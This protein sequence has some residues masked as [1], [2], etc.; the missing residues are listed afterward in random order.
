MGYKNSYFSLVT[1]ANGISMKYYP[2]MS[3]GERLKIEDITNYLHK[4]RI[5]KY[6]L[7][8]INDTIYSDKEEE[9]FISSESTYPINEYMEVTVSPDKIYAIARFYPPSDNGKRL[10][11]EEIHSDLK[12]LKI[13]SGITDEYINKHLSTP[14]YMTQMVVAKGKKPVQGQDAWIE[15]MFNTDRHAKP[16][17]NEDGTVD[18]HK[19]NNISHISEGDVLAVLHPEDVGTAGEDIYGNEIKPRKVNRAALRFGNNIRLSDDGKSLI[20]L[21]EGHVTLDGDRVSVSNLYNVEADVDNSTGDIEYNGSISVKGNVRTGFKLRAKGNVEIFGVVE[22][23]VI[24]ADGDVILHRGI[25]GMGRSQIVAGGNLISK[26]I[27]SANVAVNGYIETDT[28]L[29]SQI[30]AKGD[31]YVRGKNGNIIGGNVRSTSLIEATCIG[32][33]MGTTTCVEVGNDPAILDKVNQLKKDITEKNKEKTELTQTI[34]NLKKKLELGRLD[35]TKMP[36]LQITAKN[37]LSLDEEI[38]KLTEE[39]EKGVN[40]LSENDNARINVIKTIHQG[41]KV[42]ISGDYILIHESVPHCQYRKIKA[43]IKAAPL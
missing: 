23:A 43:E 37:I 4:N 33:P 35:K 22:G 16:Q 21:V 15:Y 2:P 30:S 20:S 24:I 38:A 14:Y 8:L 5:E 25:Q 26:F 34:V 29:H 9:V 13:V 7:K 6:D 19:L 40:Q 31:I 10:S 1:G 27:E 28:I 41:C 12:N 17:L 3:G 42:T 39:Y 18:F 11:I 36:M 32:S